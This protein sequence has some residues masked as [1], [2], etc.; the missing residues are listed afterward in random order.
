MILWW[1][2]HS[3]LYQVTMHHQVCCI[4]N[5]SRT[6]LTVQS[7]TVPQTQALLNRSPLLW[8]MSTS[9]NISSFKRIYWVS[10]NFVLD[11]VKFYADLT[12]LNLSL[13]VLYYTV[14]LWN[15]HF[16][17]TLGWSFTCYQRKFN[18]LKSSL[19][20]CHLKLI[21]M[22]RKLDRK[23]PFISAATW[24]SSTLKSGKWWHNVVLSMQCQDVTVV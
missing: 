10:W 9:P 17:T 3:H 18:L 20:I 12:I 23:S 11:A 16:W 6:R 2:P 24:R 5:I 19:W 15:A 22:Y 8:T 21:K 7:L 13:W 1:I 4:V 14:K